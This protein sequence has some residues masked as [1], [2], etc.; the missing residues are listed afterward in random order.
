MSSLYID[1]TLGQDIG[2]LSDNFEWLEYL[3]E[4]NVRSS[5]S[6]HS[7]IFNIL[8]KHKVSI[9]E[10][11]AVYCAVGPGSY[12]GMRSAAGFG[13]IVSWQGVDSYSFYHFEIPAMVGIEKGLWFCSAFKGE[14]FVYQWFKSEIKKS[15][16]NEENLMILLE[17]TKDL[18]VIHGE[19][20]NSS[21]VN[22]QSFIREN[23][24]EAFPI[25]RGLKLG[26]N[27]YY[28]RTLEK[29]FKATFKG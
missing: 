23:S 6:L 11:D 20:V 17:E 15:L 1:T 8:E 3:S 7:N 13:Q 24:K 4:P 19:Q 12:T 21:Y 2:L 25:I 5:T 26:H 10:L 14:F 27:P 9:S 29:E 22:A 28:F 16:V 18:I